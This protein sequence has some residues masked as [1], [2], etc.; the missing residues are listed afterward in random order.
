MYF[1]YFVLDPRS[2]V[3]QEKIRL[4][5]SGVYSEDS[6]NYLDYLS[7]LNV[8]AKANTLRFSNIICTIGWLTSKNET[9]G[10]GIG[11]HSIEFLGVLESE[12][13]NTK[14]NNSNNY[15]PNKVSILRGY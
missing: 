14:T 5:K 4:N 7:N 8:N 15:I 11:G 12:V 3:V 13:N 2:V 9:K 6:A 1:I 10:G